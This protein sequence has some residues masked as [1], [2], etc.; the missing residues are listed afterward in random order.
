MFGY[1]NTRVSW[2]GRAC[3]LSPG[4]LSVGPGFSTFH[5]GPGALISGSGPRGDLTFG[6]NLDRR[7]VALM[8]L[9]LR[10]S[11]Y[12]LYYQINGD[13]KQESLKEK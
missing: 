10:E 5:L 2:E 11:K 4:I 1:N 7:E 6:G 9:P 8:Q 3:S 13:S 12:F